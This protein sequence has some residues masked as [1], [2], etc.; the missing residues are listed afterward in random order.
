MTKSRPKQCLSSVEI[1]KHRFTLNTRLTEELKAAGINV[2]DFT[3]I[4]VAHHR[5]I[6]QRVYYEYDS[7]WNPTGHALAAV[8]LRMFIRQLPSR[9]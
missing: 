1:D 9:F 2:L 4:A 7:H 3:D 6:G 5:A 8:Q